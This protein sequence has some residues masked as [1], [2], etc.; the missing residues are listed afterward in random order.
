MRAIGVSRGSTTISFAPRSRAC[1]IHCI[2]IGKHSATLEPTTKMHVGER[3]VGHRER[4]AVDAERLVVGARRRRHAEPAVVVDVA[5]AEADA[6]ELAH[7]VA[8]L[9]GHRGAAVDRDGV[10]AVLGLDRL[11]ARDDVVERLVPGGALQ[12]AALAAAADQRVAQAVGVVDLLVGDDAL[13]AERAA[14]VRDSR[15]ARRRSPGRPRP[16]RYMPHCTPQK[17][18]WVGTSVSG[19]RSASAQLAAAV[20]GRLEVVVDVALRRRRSPC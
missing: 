3:D 6:G 17:E 12:R 13:G 1:Q 19:T 5:R 16:C 2:T 15:A 11:P 20:A 10:L 4:R 7:Q 8:L 9:V 18:Q 14:V